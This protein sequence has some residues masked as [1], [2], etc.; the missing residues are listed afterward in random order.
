MASVMLP[1]NC[2]PPH[3]CPPGRAE[4]P[5]T[6][7]PRPL[8]HVRPRPVDRGQ[9]GHVV[10]RLGEKH[11]GARLFVKGFFGASAL[12]KGLFTDEDFP[13]FMEP[14]S[15]TVSAQKDGYL[16]Y[17]SADIGYTVLQ[18][19]NY[20]VGAFVGYHYMN[21]RLNAMGCRQIA[22]GEPCNDALGLLPSVADNLAMITHK[23]HWH[24][25]RLGLTGDVMLTDRLTLTADAAWLPYTSISSKD[26]HWLRIHPFDLL[27]PIPMDGTG[28]SGV[29]LEAVLSYQVTPSF[30]V[31][32]GG[33]Y[34]RASTSGKAQVEG[35]VADFIPGVTHPTQP[36][37]FKTE[38]YGGFV[39]AAIKF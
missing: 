12:S 17:I 27:G 24:S 13:P 2:P 34:W 23:N 5:P 7:A 31:G 18:G 30:S 19:A 32:V 6:Q 21:E 39:Q 14:Y 22:A 38:R 29:Q 26:Y 36:L 1:S 28:H 20:R 33:R 3:W 35:V 9:Q 16:S 8:A 10:Q 11:Q 37:D 25:V 15:S 4:A